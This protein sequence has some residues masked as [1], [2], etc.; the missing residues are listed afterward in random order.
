MEYLTLLLL[1]YSLY[2]LANLD[3]LQRIA[4]IL[5][6][7]CGATVEARNLDLTITSGALAE[8]TILGFVLTAVLFRREIRHLLR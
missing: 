4:G 2:R 5:G 8:W 7:I 6:F 3:Y 1:A